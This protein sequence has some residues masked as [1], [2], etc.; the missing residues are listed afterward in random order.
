MAICRLNDAPPHSRLRPACLASLALVGLYVS[1][2][3]YGG[4]GSEYAAEVNCTFSDGSH[5][6]T[7]LEAGPVFVQLTWPW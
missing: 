3:C 2:P 7:N 1:R 6:I 5:H 4:P